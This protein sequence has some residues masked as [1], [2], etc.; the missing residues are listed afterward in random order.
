MAQTWMCSYGLEKKKNYTY[1]YNLWK[2]A[3]S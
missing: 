2:M 3:V 1:K